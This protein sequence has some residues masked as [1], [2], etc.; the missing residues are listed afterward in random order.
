MKTFP[1]EV[2]TVTDREGKMK[3]FKFRLV[4]ENGETKVFKIE[5]I[6][7]SDL[8]APFRDP[9]NKHMKY[10]CSVLIND[11]IRDVELLYYFESMKWKLSV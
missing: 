1:V 6:V 4:D 7:K 11:T 10:I 9:S 2:I 3:P 5:G 8:I